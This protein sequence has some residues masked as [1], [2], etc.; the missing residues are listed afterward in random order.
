MV[1]IVKRSV[2]EICREKKN[3]PKTSSLDNI[4]FLAAH[5][6][7]FCERIR[8]MFVVLEPEAIAELERVKL[9]GQHA[10]ERRPKH[11]SGERKL[12]YT[13]GPEV[14]VVH[15]PATRRT[16][17]IFHQTPVKPREMGNK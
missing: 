9:S 13:S 14:D 2:S 15:V 5:R 17:C 4:I 12:G 10:C 3:V 6:P 7:T 16:E 1:Y 11:C 8:V